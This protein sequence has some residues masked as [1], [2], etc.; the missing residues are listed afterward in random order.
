MKLCFLGIIL[1]KSL[2]APFAGAWIEIIAD[3]NYIKFC[4]VAPFAGAWIE[5]VTNILIAVT[6]N[7]APFAGAW[8]EI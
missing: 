1:I 3:D 2:V 4:I 6:S 5:I 8:I 7:V